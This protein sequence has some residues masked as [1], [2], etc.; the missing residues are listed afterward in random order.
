MATPKY[1]LV[2]TWLTDSRGRQY[3]AWE[4]RVP[5]MLLVFTTA[6]LDRAQK[7]GRDV[8]RDV[9]GRVTQQS[10]KRELADF[11]ARHPGV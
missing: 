8:K 6:E 10:V 1:T 3:E 4:V 11:E 9:A 7:R 2:P 5:G